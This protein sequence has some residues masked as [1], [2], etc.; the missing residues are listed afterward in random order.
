MNPNT[1][2]PDKPLTH[3]QEKFCHAILEGANQSD[4]Y[5]EA[6]NVREGTGKDSVYVSASKLMADPKVALRLEALR[7]PAVK[8]AKRS[9]EDWL[10]EIEDVAFVKTERLE[11]KTPDKLK[12]LE[13]FGKATGFIQK[14]A[15]APPNPLETASTAVLLLMLEEVKQRQAAM[16]MTLIN[17]P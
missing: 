15:T 6:Y 1:E 16:E 8:K 17:P 5:R 10:L 4:A 13:V 14:K 2:K 7:A 9:Y 12:A 3:K 11:V